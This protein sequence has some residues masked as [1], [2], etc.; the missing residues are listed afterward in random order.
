MQLWKFLLINCSLCTTFHIREVHKLMVLQ[1][2][3]STYY[4]IN[5]NAVRRGYHE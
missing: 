2:G 5:S 1:N 3:A 4:I